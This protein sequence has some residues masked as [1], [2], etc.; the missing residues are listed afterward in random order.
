ML[1]KCV[2]CY[3]N[4]RF[5][6]YQKT[7]VDKISLDL[8]WSLKAQH[9]LFSVWWFHAP[10]RRKW[11]WKIGIH[12]TSESMKVISILSNNIFS[13]WI[14]TFYYS[15]SQSTQWK[16]LII[17][18]AK[19]PM[20]KDSKSAIFVKGFNIDLKNLDMDMVEL[21]ELVDIHKKITAVM[22]ILDRCFLKF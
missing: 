6:K 16:F 14:F 22:F 21:N 3:I 4:V 20:P 13:K 1:H 8:I 11:L 18:H 7:H 15:P 5:M 2:E 17:K 12:K 10:L 9:N 19:W